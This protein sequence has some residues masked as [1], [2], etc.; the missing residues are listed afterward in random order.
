MSTSSYLRS[1]LTRYGKARGHDWIKRYEMQSLRLTYSRPSEV[2]HKRICKLC[3]CTFCRVLQRI[4]STA[5]LERLS[6]TF[7]NVFSRR[8]LLERNPH[9]IPVRNEAKFRIFPKHGP[10][11]HLH[12]QLIVIPIHSG[13]MYELEASEVQSWRLSVGVSIVHATPL[14]SGQV[15]ATANANGLTSTYS[16]YRLI[17]GVCGVG[18]VCDLVSEDATLLRWKISMLIHKYRFCWYRIIYFYWNVY[19]FE[20]YIVSNRN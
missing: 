16:M 3:G 7:H 14:K 2:S 1:F 13:Y 6:Y 8:F 19:L 15:R 20:L 5:F 17:M 11:Q 4:F 9:N 12:R 18:G 10:E